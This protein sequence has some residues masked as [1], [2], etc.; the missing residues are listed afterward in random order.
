VETLEDQFA[1][2]SV[3]F[4]GLAAAQESETVTIIETPEIAFRQT[5]TITTFEVEDA[6]RG[7]SDKTMHVRTCAKLQY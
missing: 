1:R 7:I 4:V 5:M 2:S 3:I 6:G